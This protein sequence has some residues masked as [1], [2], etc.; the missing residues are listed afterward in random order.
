VID[1]RGSRTG[2]SLSEEAYCGGL[3]YWGPWVMKGRL[4]GLASLFSWE[5]WNG[6]VYQGL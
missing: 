5:T 6:P 1:E 3:L 4:W 2:A